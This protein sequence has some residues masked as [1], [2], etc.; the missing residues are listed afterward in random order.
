MQWAPGVPHALFGRKIHQRLGRFAPRGR[1]RAF[2]IGTRDEIDWLF[3]NLSSVAARSVCSL[4]PCGGELERGV[5]TSTNLAA[6]PS[7]TLPHKGGGNAVVFD[8]VAS[9]AP[10]DPTG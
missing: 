10:V 3:E 2:E 1:E 9:S 8:V 5:A 7:L 6:T 4:P